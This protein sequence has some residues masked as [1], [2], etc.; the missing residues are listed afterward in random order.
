[1]HWIEK[2]FHWNP[3]KFDDKVFITIPVN[4]LW[5]PDFYVINTANTDGSITFNENAL[6]VVKFDGSI[7]LNIDL[8]GLN[9]RCS[10]STFKFPF[11]EQKCSIVFGSWFNWKVRF[12]QDFSISNESYLV[13]YSDNP[14]W[15]LKNISSS[16]ILTGSRFLNLTN[17]IDYSLDLNIKRKPLYYMINDIFPC[18]L[19]NALITN[20]HFFSSIY[21]LKS[22][23]TKS[24]LW[25]K[26]ILRKMKCR[27]NKMKS[28]MSSIEF[29]E[30]IST[31]NKLAFVLTF[32]TM[33]ISYFSIFYI[34][35][36]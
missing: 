10:I 31:M 20:N 23:K 30:C 34:I 4:D 28:N 9:T 22:K 1:M 6:A 25:F 36:N 26:N 18:L 14:L 19:I 11:D 35:S 27:L 13:D 7:Y 15:D 2:R 24:P 16:L 29:D 5:I 32:L 8:I 17:S 33:L 12:I 3:I 21:T